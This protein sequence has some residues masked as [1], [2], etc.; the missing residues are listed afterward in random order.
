MAQRISEVCTRDVVTMLI[1]DKA[2]PTIVRSTTKF[3][4]NR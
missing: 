2:A 1:E 3:S 4:A